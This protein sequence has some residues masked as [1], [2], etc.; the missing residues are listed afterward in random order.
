MVFCTLTANSIQHYALSNQH[1]GNKKG[2]NLNL[3]EAYWLDD[4]TI[5]KVLWNLKTVY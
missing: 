1:R 5:V 4:K 3:K 2:N